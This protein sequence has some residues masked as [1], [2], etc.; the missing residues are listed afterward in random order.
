M[1]LAGSTGGSWSTTYSTKTSE[2]SMMDEAKVPTRAELKTVNPPSSEHGD[3]LH[4]LTQ[5]TEIPL[6]RDISGDTSGT[7]F[8]F[9][10][11]TL[12]NFSFRGVRHLL[13]SD[14][15][16]VEFL[17]LGAHQ[18]S[19]ITSLMAPAAEHNEEHKG[20]ARLSH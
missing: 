3:T 9:L 10:K 8:H 12:V 18:S 5:M 17:H 15:R 11:R 4:G 19:K 20:D 7:C 1:A 13:N 14:C 6:Q 2:H 16:F